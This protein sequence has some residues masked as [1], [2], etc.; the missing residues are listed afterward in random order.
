MTGPTI[1]W[2][3]LLMLSTHQDLNLSTISAHLC[4]GFSISLS[5]IHYDT[6]SVSLYGVYETGENPAVVITYG[7]SK[8]R[9]PDLRQVV[10]G[11]AVS[12]DGGVPLISNTHRAC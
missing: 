12:G 5:E 11:M 1:D 6:T 9:R 10:V 3:T 2:M 8:D 4:S 7:H